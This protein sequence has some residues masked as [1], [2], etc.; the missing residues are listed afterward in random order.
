VWRQRRELG[1]REPRQER[2][3]E[4]ERTSRGELDA[5]DPEEQCRRR[6]TELRR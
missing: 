3:L 6:G 2:R 4:D 5:G 1:V